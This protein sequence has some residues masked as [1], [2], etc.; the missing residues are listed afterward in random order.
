M[1]GAGDALVVFGVTGDLAYKKLFPALAELAADGVEPAIVGVARS[2]GDDETLRERARAALDGHDRAAVDS[3]CRR[4]SYVRGDYADAA[5]FERIAELVSDRRLPVSFLAVPPEAFEVV[6]EG[7]AS[8]GLDRGRIVVEKPFGRDL[9]SAQELNS[10][11]SRHFAEDT[12]FRIDHFLGKES[13]QNLLVFRFANAM[14][15]SV[16]NR[17]HVARVCITMAET[18]GVDDR[19]GFYDDVGAVR[20]VVQN[21]LL[22]MVAL[23]AMEAPVAAG[24]DP[25]AQADALRTEKVKVLDAMRPVDPAE[26]VRGQYRG[27]LDEPGVAP[28]STTETFVALRL[29]ID[30]WRWAGVPFCIRAGKALDT[31]LTEAVIEFRSPPCGVFGASEVAAPTLLRFRMKPDNRIVLGLQA[32]RPGAELTSEPVELTVDYGEVLGGSGPDAYERLIG[33]AISG[34]HRLFARQDGV[35]AAWRVVAPLLD[36]DLAIEVYDPGSRGPRSAA[37]VAP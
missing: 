10:L 13:V 12:I 9:A 33:D 35:E 25:G 7:L 8:A 30:S 16:W 23:L 24:A 34:D 26:V 11:L 22:E 21:H 29:W 37:E 18:F 32:K 4:L 1:T 15:E 36:A 27:Y 3:V 31:T 6:A 5:T 20:D 17:H 28:G 19:G 14:L 2:E